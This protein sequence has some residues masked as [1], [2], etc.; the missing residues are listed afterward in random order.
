MCGQTEAAAKGDQ[1]M[2]KYLVLSRTNQAPQWWAG[3]AT[4]LA[5]DHRLGELT[6][7]AMNAWIGLL[8][9]NQRTGVQV[10][11]TVAEEFLYWASGL[12]GWDEADPPVLCYEA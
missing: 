10:T 6:D 1:V 5:E 4:R 7:E 3:S 8:T 9:T 11:N 12:D 2:A